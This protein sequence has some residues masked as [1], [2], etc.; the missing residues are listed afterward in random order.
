MAWSTTA[1]SNNTADTGLPTLADSMTPTQLDDTFRGMMAALK[2]HILDV[3]GAPAAVGGT[4]DA[5]TITTNQVISTGHQAAGFSIRFKAGGTNTGA[6]TVAVDGLTAVAVERMDGTALSA[7]DIISGGIYDIAYN[8]TNGGYTLMTAAGSYAGLGT[9]TFTAAQTISTASAGTHLTLSSSEAGAT[10]G[11]DLVLHRNS[12]TPAASDI[13]SLISFQGEDDGSV[14]TEYG[15]ILGFI[16]SP[17]GGAEEGALRF[18]VAKA[19]ST[20]NTMDLVSSSLRPVTDDGI[21]LGSGSFKWAD[22]FLASGAVIN[23]NNG[24]VTVT[25]SANALAFAEASTY[26]FDGT[27]A[28]AA[29]TLSGALTVTGTAS[30]NGGGTLGDA[31]G[32]AV[33]IKGTTVSTLG[34]TILGASTMTTVMNELSGAGAGTVAVRQSSGWSAQTPAAVLAWGFGSTTGNILWYNG[35]DWVVLAPP[36]GADGDYSLKCERV[37]GV[38]T[39]LHWEV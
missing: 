31:A 6:V 12:A 28:G 36:S 22:L 11:P 2:R 4:A 13:L 38:N 18:R 15:G 10:S 8:A 16:V 24:D 39:A 19:G 29:Q 21:A 1:A 34:T 32:D 7:G 30:L 27:I 3:G 5:I 26:T 37:A 25:H 9:N 17:T 35:S 20:T 33:V 23:F 14:A